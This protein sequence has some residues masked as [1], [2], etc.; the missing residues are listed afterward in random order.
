MTFEDFK[1][2]KRRLSTFIVSYYLVSNQSNFILKIDQKPRRFLII[3]KWLI[4]FRRMFCF[5]SNTNPIGKNNKH[6]NE[7]NR[8]KTHAKGNAAS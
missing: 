1:K 3:K 5:S 8:Y 2:K 6:L 7:T 4:V